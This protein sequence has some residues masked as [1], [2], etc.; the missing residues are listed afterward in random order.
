MTNETYV[1]VR[2]LSYEEAQKAIQEMNRI[3]GYGNITAGGVRFQGTG[4]QVGSTLTYLE[5][6]G[7]TFAMSTDHPSQVEK[8]IADNI[9]KNKQ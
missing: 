1:Y 6:T 7:N 4:D 2:L 3:G 9:K 5:N 8:R